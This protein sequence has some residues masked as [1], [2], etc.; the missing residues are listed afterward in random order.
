[1]RRT[2]IATGFW[3][4]YWLTGCAEMATSTA[5]VTSTAAAI[6]RQPI[7][8]IDLAGRLSVRYQKEGRDEALHGSFTWIQKADVTTI[9]L[10]SPLGQTLAVITVTSTSASIAQAG[11][12]IRTATDANALAAEALGWPLPV[13]GLRDWLQGFTTNAQG[14]RSAVMATTTVAFQTNDGWTLHY[15]SWD[16]TDPDHAHPKRLD[17]TR[18]TVEAGEVA[19]R[20]VIDSWQPL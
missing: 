3:L 20:L 1:M 12:P 5:P 8:A 16:N 17:L 6:E 9:S 2:A 4:C 10:L 14:Q 7:T 11:S 18:Q 19:I 13:A 15:A